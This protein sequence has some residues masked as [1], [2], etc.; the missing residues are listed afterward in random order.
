MCLGGGERREGFECRVLARDLHPTPLYSLKHEQTKGTLN[1]NTQPNPAN[2][3]PHT[4]PQHTPL[5]VYLPA[6]PPVLHT[7]PLFSRCKPCPDVSLI[8][9]QQVNLLESLCKCSLLQFNPLSYFPTGFETITHVGVFTF[10][11]PMDSF[12]HYSW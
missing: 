3:D 9:T 5:V 4:S 2:P 6:R 7:Y 11:S 1:A 10:H 8:F 12:V